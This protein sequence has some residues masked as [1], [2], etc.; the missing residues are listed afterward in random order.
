MGRMPF[1]VKNGSPTYQRVIT[2]TFLTGHK[3][4]N[5]FTI[6]SDLPIH[7]KKLRKCQKMFY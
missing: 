2:K 4:L 5:D 3:H 6:F 7:V 1:G